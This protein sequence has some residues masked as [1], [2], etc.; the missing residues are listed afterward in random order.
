MQNKI[1]LVL[2]TGLSG[3]GKTQA[4]RTLEELKEVEIDFD[5]LDEIKKVV[6]MSAEKINE[7]IA[8]KLG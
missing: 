7:Y 2:V 6:K 1:E 8:G 4:T 5:I 3:A